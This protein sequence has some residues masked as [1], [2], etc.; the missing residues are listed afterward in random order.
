MP[1]FRCLYNDREQFVFHETAT[2]YTAG[3]W[4]SLFGFVG[5]LLA[6]LILL[7]LNNP[8]AAILLA[9]VVCYF[10]IKLVAVTFHFDPYGSM[11]LVSLVC[12]GSISI[13]LLDQSLSSYWGLDIWHT[14]GL[15]TICFAIVCPCVYFY[16]QL[17]FIADKRR[18]QLLL[19]T[20]SRSQANRLSGGLIDFIIWIYRFITFSDKFNFFPPPSPSSTS[21]GISVR[22]ETLKRLKVVFYHPSDY[23][24][25]VP[26]G[27]IG[28]PAV[29]FLSPGET[30]SFDPP[31]NPDSFKLKVFSPGFI[32]HELGYSASAHRGDLWAVFDVHRKIV[33]FNEP[34]LEVTDAPVR[35]SQGRM[36]RN[37]SSFTKLPGSPVS[38]PTASQDPEPVEDEVL[39]KNECSLPLE[40]A[41]FAELSNSFLFPKGVNE[42]M[43]NRKIGQ[44]AWA[45]FRLLKDQR[46]CLRVT[47]ATG[48]VDYCVVSGGKRY[49]VSDGLI[50]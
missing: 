33:L 29:G 12:F 3:G 14:L 8:I 47:F 7:A 39:V 25:W 10:V 9:V 15:Y 30:G 28:G 34:V 42:V 4:A 11:I 20:R 1:N 27:G 50:D 2:D 6:G 41:F 13:Y 31:A 23:C 17:A 22:N 32:D 5:G 38:T 37:P 44:R 21:D 35:E 49:L 40:V 18:H 26:V 43:G 46:L 19:I 24:C 45:R 48:D 16:A 36:R